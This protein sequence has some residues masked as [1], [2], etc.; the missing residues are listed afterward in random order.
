MV[1]GGTAMFMKRALIGVAAFAFFATEAGAADMA[2]IYKAMPQ[3]APQPVSGY[4]E[5]SSGWGRSEYSDPFNKDS[6]DGW[7]LGG[8]ARGT[9]W[10]S[11]NATVQLDAQ[12]EGT[13]FRIPEGAGGHMSEHGYLVG[14]HA[15][16]R[17]ARY[18]WGVFGAAG[19][20]TG[21]T[22]LLAGMSSAS[23]VRHGLVGLEG[24][25]YLGPLTLY[26]QVGYDTS[27]GSPLFGNTDSV[28]A[29]F[30][31]GTGRY[32][33]TPNTRLEGT[34]LYANGKIDAVSSVV[35][36]GGSFDIWVARAKV[37]HKLTNS[38]FSIFAAYDWA[39]TTY[40]HGFLSNS[41]FDVTNQKL[42]GG[43][44]LYLNEG[45]LQWND[46]KGTT[47]DIIDVLRLAPFG[48]SSRV[49]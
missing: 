49:Q 19:D 26:G 13:S 12:G 7:V 17:D 27:V 10:W 20:T 14:A 4:V 39:R 47:L 36:P 18:L 24:Q 3:A 33:V 2:P 31:R 40:D 35:L 16:W 44:R 30:V 37:E 22:P 42:V 9:Y 23:S 8:A 21:L 15:S 45:T 46:N 1:I 48:Y 43:V 11:R 41:R 6:Y 34:V 28:H 29:W 32:N 5:L 25:A 38:P